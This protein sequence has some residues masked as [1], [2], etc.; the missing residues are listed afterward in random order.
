MTI[1]KLCLPLCLALSACA[2]YKPLYNQIDQTHVAPGQIEMQ[3]TERNIGERRVAQQVYQQLL[4]VFSRPD[5]AT[6]R[7]DA[8]IEEKESTLSV[9][10]D[11]TIQ[12]A[13]LNLDAQVQLIH[14]ETN[15]PAHTFNV[16]ATSA[17]NTEDT[18]FGTESGRMFAR[19]AAAKTLAEDITSI[20]Q[21]W[22]R[23]QDAEETEAAK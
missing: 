4:R 10:R 13:S 1:Y 6:Y 22:L 21:L 15:K 3:I 9:Q 8:V 18:P 17:Y 20:V 23:E 11:A 14:Q 16:D 19:E 12:R 7:I 2:G 5:G